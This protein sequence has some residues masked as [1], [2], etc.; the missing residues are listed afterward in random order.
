MWVFRSMSQCGCL[1]ACLN[2]GVTMCIAF[3]WSHVHYI[4]CKIVRDW[5]AV[6]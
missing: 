4:C 5:G 3:I 1:G 2:V 6:G